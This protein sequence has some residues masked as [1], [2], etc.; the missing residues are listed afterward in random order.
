MSHRYFQEN[1]RRRFE[2]RKFRMAA[3]NDAAAEIDDDQRLTWLLRSA[4]KPD[5]YFAG[6][7]VAAIPKAIWGQF[8]ALATELQNRRSG[9]V[10]RQ[11]VEKHARLLLSSCESSADGVGPAPKCIFGQFDDRPFISSAVRVSEQSWKLDL[12]DVGVRRYVHLIDIS[13]LDSTGC[14]RSFPGCNHFKGTY[15][16]IVDGTRYDIK[17]AAGDLIFDTDKQ[18]LIHSQYRVERSTYINPNRAGQ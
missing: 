2:F 5:A 18:L 1:A 9:L 4:G 7:F 13:Q 6:V 3:K 14:D 11:L 17:K 15:Q 12:N 10:D 16:L 8:T